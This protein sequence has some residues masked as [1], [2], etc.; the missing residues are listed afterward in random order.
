MCSLCGGL[1][2]EQHWTDRLEG[3]GAEAEGP[4]AWRQSRQAQVG[5]ANRILSQ[6]G[7][8]VRD[9]DAHTFVLSNRTGQSELVP[10][11][12]AVW[13]TAERLGRCRCD[14]LN[15]VLLSRLEREEGVDEAAT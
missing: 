8:E 6:H 12:A 1:E 2:Q 15:P 11:L 10:R 14:P 3:T 4:A 5:L 7:L 9:W 13:S